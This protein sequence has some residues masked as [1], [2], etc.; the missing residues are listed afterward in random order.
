M[1]MAVAVDWRM[2]ASWDSGEDRWVRSSSMGEAGAEGRNGGRRGAERARGGERERER[3]GDEEVGV[4]R[5]GRSKGEERCGE[6][7]R[8]GCGDEEEGVKRREDGVKRRTR[9]C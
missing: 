6:G 8:E 1:A 3:E 7:R 4:R 2:A 9:L 5:R